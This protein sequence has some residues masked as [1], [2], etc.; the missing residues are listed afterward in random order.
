MGQEV[1]FFKAVKRHKALD[2]YLFTASSHLI[3][4]TMDVS[5]RE[6]AVIP[7]LLMRNLKLTEPQHCVPW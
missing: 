5:G 6:I 1:C 4:I 2:M 3:F 7:V